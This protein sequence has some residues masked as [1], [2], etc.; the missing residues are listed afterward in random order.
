MVFQRNLYWIKA[1]NVESEL[2]KDLC[3]I[4]NVDKIRTTPYHPMTNGPC[5]RFNKILCNMLGT[6]ST[7][8]KIDCK[9]QIEAVTHAYNCTKNASTNF[10][11]YFL[12]FGRYPRLPK[13][14]A[15]GLHR[16]SNNVAFSK[17]RYVD[18]LKKRLDYAYDKAKSFSERNVQRTKQRYDRKAKFVLLEP[19]DVVLIMKLSHTGKHKIQNRW[20]DEE[21]IIVSWPNSAT[22]VYIVHPVVGDKQRTLHKNLLLPLGY[23]LNE[24]EDSDEEIEMVSSVEVKHAFER[25]RKPIK[26]DQIDK[27]ITIV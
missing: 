3:R 10:C 12:M 11:P 23:K 13:D 25:V 4:A 18:R 17:S 27:S 9:S 24:V 16:T 15:F 5:E 6:L 22:P 21:Y 1:R 7:K 8:D 26:V 14:V 2:I 20:K 19:N